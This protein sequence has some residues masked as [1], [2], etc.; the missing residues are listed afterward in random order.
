MKSWDN[1]QSAVDLQR[2]TLFCEFIQLEQVVLS[3]ASF[4]AL[5][6]LFLAVPEGVGRTRGSKQRTVNCKN[7]SHKCI[8]RH[9]CHSFC[10]IPALLFSHSDSFTF[11][12][13][14]KWFT[15]SH[16]QSQRV[17]LSLSSFEQTTV[18]VNPRNTHHNLLL[19]SQN[20]NQSSSYPLASPNIVSQTL[21]QETSFIFRNTL[22][23][24][25]EAKVNQA[26][27]CCKGGT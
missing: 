23:T 21:Q 15:H 11:P 19:R 16:N 14:S 26:T 24:K 2:K 8:W 17:T 4:D 22:N 25:N 18:M 3:L 6:V 27:I 5:S 20:S 12:N 10:S 9:H 7:C 1:N 13:S